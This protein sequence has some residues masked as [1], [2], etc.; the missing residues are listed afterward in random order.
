[1]ANGIVQAVGTLAERGTPVTKPIVCRI[2]GN[3]A[4]EGRRILT[5]FNHPLVEMVET[6]DD[7]ARRVA[8]LAGG[9]A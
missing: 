1:V 2:D 8:Q 7:A 6:M 5:E 9:A 4:V 3:N